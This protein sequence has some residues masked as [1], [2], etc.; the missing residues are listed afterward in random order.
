[1]D[2]NTTGSKSGWN[3][4]DWCREAGFSKS[5]YYNLEGEGKAPR[6]VKIRRRRLII[7]APA[8]YLNRIGGTSHAA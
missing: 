7:E 2:T 5:T 1:M 6:S 8:D 4:L 3:I